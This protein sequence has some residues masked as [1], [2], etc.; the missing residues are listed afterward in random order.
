M[1]DENFWSCLDVLVSQSKV[2]IDRP[3]G[4]AHPRYPGFIYPHDYG[5]LQGTQSMDQGGIDVW[6]GSLPSRQITGVVC[7]V[8][9]TK[10]DS[11]IKILLGCTSAEADAILAVHNSGTQAAI[12]ITKPA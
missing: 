5:Y 1:K 10:K 12:L 9:L 3:A 6:V 11:E 8:D 4:T 7:S 2:V